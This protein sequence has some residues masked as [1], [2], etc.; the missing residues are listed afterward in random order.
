MIRSPLRLSENETN[1]QWLLKT[2]RDGTPNAEREMFFDIFWKTIDPHRISQSFLGVLEGSL[3][4]V[5]T[6]TI[7]GPRDCRRDVWN[8][9]LERRLFLHFLFVSSELY[10]FPCVLKII[11]RNGRQ[12]RGEERDANTK[13]LK[14]QFI[15]EVNEVNIWKTSPVWFRNWPFVSHP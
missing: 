5:L 9:A 6:T 2:L 3:E 15:F 13:K 7:T 10:I 12:A 14:I 11:M 4:N 1:W 8:R